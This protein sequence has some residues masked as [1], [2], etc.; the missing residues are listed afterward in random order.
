MCQS[1]KRK[2]NL[3]SDICDGELFESH[4]LYQKF[5]GALQLITCYDEV[6]PYNVLGAQTGIHKL[7]K[8]LKGICIYIPSLYIMSI[9]AMFY[10]TLGNIRPEL[11]STHRAIQ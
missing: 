3:L 1:H 8:F 11:R 2:N 9:L 5:P 10:Y 6:E 4:E 7:G